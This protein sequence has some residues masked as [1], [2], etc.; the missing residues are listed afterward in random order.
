MKIESLMK[1]PETDKKEIRQHVDLGSRIYEKT[2]EKK[3]QVSYSFQQLFPQNLT[4]S[5]I[6]FP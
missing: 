5:S 6:T 1:K 3:F 2:E 4:I